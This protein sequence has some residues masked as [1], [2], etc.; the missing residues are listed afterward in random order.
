MTGG[1]AIVLATLTGAV[2]GGSYPTVRMVL[3]IV[4]PDRPGSLA[5]TVAEAINHFIVAIPVYA[6]TGAA[7]CFALSHGIRLVVRG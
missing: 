7:V 6:L 3:F 1:K 2:L 5:M 4:K